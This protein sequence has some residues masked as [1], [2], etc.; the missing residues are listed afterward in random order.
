MTSN[1]HMPAHVCAYA[2]PPTFTQRNLNTHTQALGM[3]EG[4]QEGRYKERWEIP[5]HPHFLWGRTDRTVTT[6]SLY[7]VLW[8]IRRGME[9]LPPAQT[10]PT[11]ESTL[12]GPQQRAGETRGASSLCCLKWCLE[13]QVSMLASG[14]EL[15]VCSLGFAASGKFL[16]DCGRQWVLL[17]LS[18]GLIKSF[19]LSQS[20][21][22]LLGG[23]SSGDGADEAW[24]WLSHT[25]NPIQLISTDTH[26]SPPSFCSCFLMYLMKMLY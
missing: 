20:C 11:Q 9:V 15:C 3:E 10:R 16:P 18:L 4:L 22:H 1:I 6:M 26:Q 24:Q 12:G 19:H 25:L 8:C 5:T 2:P 14:S 17:N 21:S 7:Q 13:S 23:G